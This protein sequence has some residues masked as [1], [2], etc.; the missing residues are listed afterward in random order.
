MFVF[1]FVFVPVFEFLFL[2]L[3]EVSKDLRLSA[4]I[5]PGSGSNLVLSDMLCTV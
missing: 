3:S 5:K 2:L 1:V 4:G